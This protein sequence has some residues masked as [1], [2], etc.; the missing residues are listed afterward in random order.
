[1]SS[2]SLNILYGHGH[3]YNHA[4]MSNELKRLLVFHIQIRALCTTNY[5]VLQAQKNLFAIKRLS[6]MCAYG[7]SSELNEGLKQEKFNLIK[8]RIE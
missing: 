8:F 2:A 4:E 7:E 3:A 5:T 6:I 1:M